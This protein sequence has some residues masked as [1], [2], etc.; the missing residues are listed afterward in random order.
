[1][2]HRPETVS[3]SAPVLPGAIAGS[4]ILVSILQGLLFAVDRPLAP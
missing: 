2:L 4:A 1:M 3:D